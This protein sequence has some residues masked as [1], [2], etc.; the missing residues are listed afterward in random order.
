MGSPFSM[1]EQSQ[2]TGIL[3]VA[4]GLL[5][6]ALRERWVRGGGSGTQGVGPGRG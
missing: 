6:S 2:Q 5:G 4:E 3:D 1:G